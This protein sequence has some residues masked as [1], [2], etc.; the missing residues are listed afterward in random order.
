[1]SAQP[2]DVLAVCPFCGQAAKVVTVT[3][4]W[5]GVGCSSSTDARVMCNGVASALQHASKEAAIAAWNQRAPNA[6]VAELLEADREYDAAR[7]AVY[8]RDPFS[9][10]F[11]DLAAMSDRL[12][13][14]T[15]R[16][17]AALARIGG[18]A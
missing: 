13:Y 10:K 16:R 12:T 11:R 18:A 4:K 2:V 6:A 9:K 7:D 1:M 8:S 14:A 5:F 15:E 3:G 17:E